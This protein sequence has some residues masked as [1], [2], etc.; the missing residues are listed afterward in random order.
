MAR[1]FAIALSCLCIFSTGANA[2]DDAELN[3]QTCGTI[4][5]F[6]YKGADTPPLKSNL[7]I[8]QE[9]ERLMAYLNGE[10][11]PTC[12]PGQIWVREKQ[13]DGASPLVGECGQR[14]HVQ[15]RQIAQQRDTIG[16]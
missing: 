13:V 12:N 14:L 6:I 16:N 7:A 9:V 5:V 4:L 11:E 10:P 2:T 1:K 3:S 8:A 15:A